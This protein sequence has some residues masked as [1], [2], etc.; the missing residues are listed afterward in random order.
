M[1][2]P[3]FEYPEYHTSLDDLRLVTPEALA[4]SLRMY[5]RMS[6]RWRR[7]RRTP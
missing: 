2:T 1:R 7:P 5:H 6:R 3:Y 4:G